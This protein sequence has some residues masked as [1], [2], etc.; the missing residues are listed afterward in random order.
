MVLLQNAAVRVDAPN[1]HVGVLLLEVAPG[2]TD[3]AAGAYAHNKVGD[4]PFGL[5]PNFRTGGSVM[6]FLV[7][8][9]VVLVAPEA[10]RVRFLAALRHAVIAV[11]MVC[12]DVGRADV[13]LRPH[14]FEDVDFF[15]RL[16]IA[17]GANELVSLHRTRQ[18]QTHAGV[19]TGALDDGTARLEESLLLGVLHHAQGHAVLDT[20]A[21]VEI[22][23]L[24]VDRT[25]KSVDD[26]LQLDHRRIANGR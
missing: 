4:A 5:I 24:R 18:R 20:V 26:I 3:G 11:R 16:L 1:L 10:V 21:R 23:H 14:R 6:R 12:F 13:H 9:V 19:S 8:Q 22:L 7:G 25:G 15:L 2:A 17:H